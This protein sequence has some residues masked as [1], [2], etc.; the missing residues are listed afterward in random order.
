VERADVLPVL[1]QKRHQIVDGQRD[2]G[3]QLVGGHAN[4]S[5]SHRKAQHL[6][7]LE[8]DGGLNFVSL[9]DHRLVVRQKSRELASLVET[10][11]QQ[12]RNLLDERLRSEEGVVALGELLHQ[13][14]VLVELPQRFSIHAWEVVGFRLI[15]MLLVTKNANREL[16][17][18]DV[19]ELDGS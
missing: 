6:L 16:R 3:S 14:L 4:V 15:A 19:L 13:L 1:L 8:L 10:G 18:R 2:V 12:T 11:A 5:D 7:H 9:G 17:T